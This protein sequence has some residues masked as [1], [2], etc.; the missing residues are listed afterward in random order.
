ME[1]LDVSPLR[2]FHGGDYV[3]LG[4]LFGSHEKVAYLSDVK[5]VCSFVR[6]L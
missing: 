2:V 4:F 5:E 1:G 3:C 6:C